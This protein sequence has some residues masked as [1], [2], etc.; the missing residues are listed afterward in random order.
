MKGFNIW[1]LICVA[2]KFWFSAEKFQFSAKKI[3]LVPKSFNLEPKT[4]NLVPKNFNFE[5]KNIIF[6]LPPKKK[7]KISAKKNNKKITNRVDWILRKRVCDVLPCL[8]FWL[9]SRFYG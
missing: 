9:E 6:T 5:Q 2:E 4:F 8:L 3:N 1:W 7:I